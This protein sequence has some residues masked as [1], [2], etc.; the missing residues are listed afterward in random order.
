MIS[1]I[2]EI[3]KINEGTNKTGKRP[4]YRE[5]RVARR[6]E[7]VGMGKMDEG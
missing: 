5:L 6:K 4:I 2:R 7:G 1:L 3:E